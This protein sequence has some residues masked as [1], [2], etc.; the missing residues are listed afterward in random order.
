MILAIF[1]LTLLIVVPVGVFLW[2]S[3]SDNYDENGVVKQSLRNAF[4]HFLQSENLTTKNVIEMLSMSTEFQKILGATKEQSAD[5]MTLKDPEFKPK[6]G[7]KRF[8][9][10]LKP[11]YLIYGYM[12]NKQIKPSL[13]ADLLYIQRKS[14]II[15]TSIS[16]MASELAM[17]MHDPRY[18]KKLPLQGLNNLIQSCQLFYQGIWLHQSS[19][20]QLPYMTDD[21]IKAIERKLKKGVKLSALQKMDRAELEKNF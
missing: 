21:S 10:F 15:L 19:L 2:Q 11:F 5:L 13:Q 3:D 7:E 12:N 8:Y 16:D 6:L 17:G 14:R 18:I 20:K 9:A 1:F 4:E